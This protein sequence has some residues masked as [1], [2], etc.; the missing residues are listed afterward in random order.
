MYLVLSDLG[1]VL[2]S[3]R[4]IRKAIKRV[5]AETGYMVITNHADMIITNQVLKG[6]TIK[7]VQRLY[8][9]YH[10]L[11]P[12]KSDKDKRVV[13]AVVSGSQLSGPQMSRLGPIT[14]WRRHP[15]SPPALPCFRLRFRCLS[16]ISLRSAIRFGLH[17][18]SGWLLS[19]IIIV[20]TV[21]ASGRN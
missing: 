17:E 14:K 10:R 13:R 8:W 2:V 18:R 5:G 4:V 16:P 12:P 1:G 7:S 15:L 3:V 9:M 11:Q 19:C 21:A 20:K 6:S